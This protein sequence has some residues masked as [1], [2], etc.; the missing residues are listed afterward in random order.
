[1]ITIHVWKKN[2]KLNLDY[3]ACDGI[4][5]HHTNGYVARRN[6]FEMTRSY[7]KASTLDVDT[8]AGRYIKSQVE[9]STGS[10]SWYAVHRSKIHKKI[11]NETRKYI[12]YKV[13]SGGYAELFPCASSDI[14]GKKK[15][16]PIFYSSREPNNMPFYFNDNQLRSLIWRG[17]SKTSAKLPTFGFWFFVKKRL[18]SGFYVQQG[19]SKVKI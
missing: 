6:G 10:Y 15:F 16:L 5:C 1:M 17:L 13:E 4:V 14:Y 3:L 18:W 11:F 9:R 12:D 8:G 7:P 19:S 2:T